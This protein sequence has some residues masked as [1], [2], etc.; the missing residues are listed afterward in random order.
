MKTIQDN[1]ANLNKEYGSLSTEEV[2][3]SVMQQFGE[4]LPFLQAWELKIRC[5]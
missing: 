1:I 2:L 4:R 3:V 5:Y